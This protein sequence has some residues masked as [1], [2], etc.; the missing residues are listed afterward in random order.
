[1]IETVFVDV[2][3]GCAF[4]RVLERQGDLC[5]YC[6]RTAPPAAAGYTFSRPRISN[7]L[8]HDRAVMYGSTSRTHRLCPFVL[9]CIA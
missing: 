4:V 1:M 6:G 8:F 5:H 7:L 3:F 2:W 9:P